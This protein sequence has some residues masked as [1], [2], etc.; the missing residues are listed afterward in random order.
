M[1][2]VTKKRLDMTGG[3]LDGIAIKGNG[4]FEVRGK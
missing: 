1:P 4:M 3:V 2:E